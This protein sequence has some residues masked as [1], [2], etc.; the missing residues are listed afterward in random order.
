M[1]TPSM[2]KPGL[3]GKLCMCICVIC[4]TFAFVGMDE[5]QD[6]EQDEAT[7]VDLLPGDCPFICTM[8]MHLQRVI[9]LSILDVC[10][11]VLMF[12]VCVNNLIII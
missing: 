5:D 10:A 1:K 4:V 9:N 8:T 7:D 3:Q 11:F 6:E 12:K 2:E